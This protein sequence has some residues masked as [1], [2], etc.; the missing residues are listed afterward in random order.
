MWSLGGN[1]YSLKYDH[2][3]C[4]HIPLKK[5]SSRRQGFTINQAKR[6]IPDRSA[7]TTRQGIS[8]DFVGSEGTSVIEL[9]SDNLLR[10]CRIN[11][12]FFL[13]SIPFRIGIELHA[14]DRREERR[15]WL[16]ICMPQ[17][18]SPKTKLQKV[19]HCVASGVSA[20]SSLVHTMIQLAAVRR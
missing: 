18:E 14:F 19:F 11:P 12:I 1:I 5:G 4:S 7:E 13:C 9:V 10:L 6:F 16:N 8:W 3:R 20:C 17:T 2:N 15:A